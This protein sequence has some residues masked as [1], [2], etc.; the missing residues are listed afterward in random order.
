MYRPLG[1][2]L[3]DSDVA[4]LVDLARTI[5]LAPGPGG[6]RMTPIAGAQAIVGAS[7]PGLWAQALI[8]VLLPSAQLVG[9]CDPPIAGT[10]VHLPIVSNADCWSFSDGVWQ[11]LVIGT[12]YAMDPT[13][14]HGA[15]NWGATPRLHLMIDTRV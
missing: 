14:P 2:R 4:A 15:V 10:R 5:D 12:G 3:S 9:H 13:K 7:I 11:Q 8:V 6:S 1:W